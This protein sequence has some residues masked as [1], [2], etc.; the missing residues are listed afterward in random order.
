VGERTSAEFTLPLKYAATQHG[1]V[2]MAT[3]ADTTTWWRN[4]RSMGQAQVLL[5]GTWV[6]MTA[7]ALLGSEDPEAVTPL[8]RVYAAR[9]PKVVKTLEGA[10]LE[11][12]VNRA[13]LV[14]L[15]PAR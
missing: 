9:F 15:R 1:I 4:F 8:L 2:V 12:R 7:H 10:N 14:W 6:P 11:Q 5:A 3:N 13:V